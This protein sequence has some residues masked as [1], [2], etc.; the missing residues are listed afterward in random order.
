[1]LTVK[2][3]EKFKDQHNKIYGYRLVDLNGEI[4]D[5]ASDN[6]KRAIA[7][8]QVQVINLT[9]TKD[10]RL[11]D[12]N[13]KQL[14]SK[15]LGKSPIRNNASS[16]RK[17]VFFAKLLLIE[18]RFC[19]D[20]GSGDP[21]RGKD[22]LETAS[23]ISYTD[24]ILNVLYDGVDVYGVT[25]DIQFDKDEHSIS[26]AWQGDNGMGTDEFL[27]TAN[28]HSPLFSK[29]NMIIISRAFKEFTVKAEDWL[30]PFK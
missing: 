21:G 4:Q 15:A 26:I 8:K 17:D 22:F 16:T 7:N 28:L 30:K 10:N 12:C 20:I 1:M 23:E 14:Q 9:L 27:V 29:E 11:V 3:T 19:K 2:C 13:S 25:V 6:L 5:V 18:Q 24:Q